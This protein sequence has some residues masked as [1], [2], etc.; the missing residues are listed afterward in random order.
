MS[1]RYTTGELAKICGVTVRTVQYY[2]NQNLLNPS[3]L[4]E[5]GRRLYSE[6]DRHKMELICTL[7]DLGLSLEVI[8]KIFKEENSK[9]VVETFLQ[10]QKEVLSAEL[11]E[12]KQQV[13]RISNILQGIQSSENYSLQ[14]IGDIVKSM[15]DKKKLRKLHMK[16]IIAGIF[17]DAVQIGTFIAG[18]RTG[19]WIPFIIGMLFAIS[20]GL[21]V[22]KYMQGKTA[23]ICPDCH[24]VFRP[25]FGEML[26][27]N[28]TPKTRKLTCAAC[29]HKSFC[30]E[31]CKEPTVGTA[32]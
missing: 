12:K 28:H 30:V 32:L 15:E 4:T 5:G 23:Y 2:D 27:A 26:F 17:L 22:A 29:G 31:T 18:L 10:E 14:L 11:E 24:A 9:Q 6:E 13:L 1:N 3:E 21:C 25:H 19:N 7:R 20:A 16:M 8:H